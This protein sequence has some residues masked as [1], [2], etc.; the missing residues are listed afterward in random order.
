M[1]GNRDKYGPFRVLSTMLLFYL[2]RFGDLT[3]HPSSGLL[4]WIQSVELVP[5][6]AL[7]LRVGVTLRLAV[8]WQSINLGDKPLETHNQ[9]F[10]FITKHLRS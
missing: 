1:L 8:Y 9:H 6:P 4:R 7:R 2:K 5:S 3:L 10:S